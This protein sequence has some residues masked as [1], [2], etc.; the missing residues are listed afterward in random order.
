MLL[1]EQIDNVGSKIMH[2][3]LNVIIEFCKVYVF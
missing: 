3:N 1:F 2:I